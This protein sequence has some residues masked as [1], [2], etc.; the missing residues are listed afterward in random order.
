[1]RP[2]D[3]FKGEGHEPSRPTKETSPRLSDLIRR[4]AKPSK[5]GMGVGIE[6][7]PRRPSHV[8][9][10]AG[11]ATPVDQSGLTSKEGGTEGAGV[12]IEGPSA[13]QALLEGQERAD[14]PHLSLDTPDELFKI[15]KK[16][17]ET[18][19][20]ILEAVRASGSFSISIVERVAEFLV[21]SLQAGDALMLSF[22][23]TGG[24]SPA[25]A[26]EAVN[27]CIVSTKLGLELGYT[28]DE[29]RQ[30]SLAALLHDI[31]MVR[32]PKGLERKGPLNSVEQAL[33]GR[34]VREGARIVRELGPEYNWLA[35]VISQVHER[36]D[37]SGYPRQLKGTDVHEYAQIVGLADVYES[38]VHDRPHRQRLTPVEA[39]KEI[40]NRERTAFPD[41]IL[42]ALIQ[43][44]SP[45]PVGSLVR[46]NTGEIGRVVATNKD[47]PLRP[48]AEILFRGGKQLEEPAVIDLSQ[49]P[50]LNVQESIIEE[51]L[52]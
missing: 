1:M 42:K 10:P 25:P 49:S 39:L 15:F 41:R 6:P 31:G 13:E 30:L 38:L 11:E 2:K 45:Y 51:S 48:V 40:L 50:L 44:L 4:Q 28:D 47:H 24:P 19:D 21:Q 9:P 33:L 34:H 29:L 22:F 32:L 7:P 43:T 20:G 16:A 3:M 23:A 18:I 8:S 5:R 37:G 12:G 35:E 27:V 46:L 26:L 17:V 36:V 14:P 52:P